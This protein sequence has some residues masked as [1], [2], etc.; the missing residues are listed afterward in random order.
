MNMKKLLLTYLPLFF[1]ALCISCGCNQSQNKDINSTP[2]NKPNVIVSTLKLDMKDDGSVI[3]DTNK[4]FTIWITNKTEQPVYL[5]GYAI[6]LTIQGSN[7]HDIFYED[8]QAKKQKLNNITNPITTF[9]KQKELKSG[10]KIAIKLELTLTKN[11][12][13]TAIKAV[14]YKKDKLEDKK[15]IVIKCLFVTEEMIK[16]V[17]NYTVSKDSVISISDSDRDFLVSVLEA[18]QKGDNSAINDATV[19]RKR[20]P[21]HI[22]CILGKSDMVEVLLNNGA[23][24]EVKDNGDTTP[25]QYAL[26][27]GSIETMKIL[28]DKGADSKIVLDI[29]G[30]NLTLLDIAFMLGNEENIK[31]LLNR[32]EKITTER[33][34]VLL[35]KVIKEEKKNVAKLLVKYGADVNTKDDKGNTLLHIVTDK[36]TVEELLAKGAHVNITN[37][38]GETP[39]KIIADKLLYDTEDTED[40]WEILQLLLQEKADTK[41]KDWQGQTLLAKAI[42]GDNFKLAGL[43]IKHDADVNTTNDTGETPLKIVVDKLIDDTN[44]KEDEFKILQLLLEKKANTEVKDKDNNTLLMKATKHNNFKLAE[45][46]IKYDAH[47]NAINDAGETPLKIVVDELIYDTKNKEDEWKILQLLLE[48]KADTEVKDKHNNTL[49]MKATKHNNFTLAELLIK[50]DADVN[51]TNNAGETPLKIVTDK[52]PYNHTDT[53]L[54]EWKILQLLLE[55]KADTEVKDK[56]KNTLLMKSI[57]YRQFKLAELLIK[58]GANVNAPNDA[59]E[60]PLKIVVDNF[61]YDTEDTEDEWKILQLLLEKKADTEVKYQHGNTLLTKFAERRNLNLVKLF[62]KYG[63]DVN[64]TNNRGQTPLEIICEKLLSHPNLKTT[65]EDI[66]V[67][68]LLLEN[69]ANIEKKDKGGNTLLTEFVRNSNLKLVKLFIEYGADVYAINNYGLTALEIICNKLDSIDYEA[70]KEDLE[71]IELLLLLENKDNIDKKYA[72]GKTLLTKFVER[73]DLKPAALFIKYGAD[74]NTIDDAGETPLHIAVYKHNKDMVQLLLANKAD[75]TLLNGNNKTAHDIA[76]TYT[77]YTDIINLLK[78]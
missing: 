35:A 42:E 27:S 14:L 25:L 43:L 61:L 46:L 65:E 7:D 70:T 39:S 45:L 66:E 40:K 19:D 41:T 2:N 1:L 3:I 18:I 48:K 68:E 77:K 52:L 24:I 51:A 47:V 13:P 5:E 72:H 32:G 33:L 16:Y 36:E 17:E 71:I 23:N 8:L 60:T 6:D 63:A 37:N 59:D 74:V 69:K 10:E 11:S 58:H 73:G 76:K 64:I 62:I 54:H 12:L 31:F 4:E 26:I 53:Q 55:K 57:Q 50:H 44:N 21:L 75:K 49:L 67:I 29:D 56:H 9:T 78:P 38:A 30:V 22:A 28:L 20:T 34:S 15:E